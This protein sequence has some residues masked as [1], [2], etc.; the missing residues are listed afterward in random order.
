MGMK[1]EPDVS[2]AAADQGGLGGT[3]HADG[4]IGFLLQQI[5]DEIRC[6]QF[7][8]QVRMSLLKPGEDGGKRFGGNHFARADANR[9]AHVLHV[10]GG[11]A[12][13]GRRHGSHGLCV[14]LHGQGFFGRQKSLLGSQKEGR[15]EGLLQ[16]LDVPAGGRLGEPERPRSR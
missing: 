11:D 16:C 12:G 3:H 14:R 9:P 10:A 2:Y 13:K 5:F 7:N 1:A 8:F 6:G 15:S 4:N